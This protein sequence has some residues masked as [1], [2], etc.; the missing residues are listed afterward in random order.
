MEKLNFECHFEGGE[1]KGRM[2]KL[3][4]RCITSREKLEELDG[5]SLA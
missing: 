3:N 1:K 2:E 5:R 4:F